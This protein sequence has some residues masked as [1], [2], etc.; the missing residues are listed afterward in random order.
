MFCV[1][2]IAQYIPR[3]KKI[4]IISF[5]ANGCIGAMIKCYTVY[6]IFKC[7]TSH[8]SELHLLTSSF[9]TACMF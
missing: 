8:V 2:N 9:H 6:D 7:I 3:E 1:H 5:Q 4:N